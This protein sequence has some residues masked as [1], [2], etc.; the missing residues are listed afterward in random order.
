MFFVCFG[1]L[2]NFAF[3]LITFILTVNLAITARHKTDTESVIA[4]VLVKTAGAEA[5]PLDFSPTREAAEIV[6]HLP[7]MVAE[8]KAGEF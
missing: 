3:K 4:G 8:H 2:Q 6:G 1:F 5:H 7:I